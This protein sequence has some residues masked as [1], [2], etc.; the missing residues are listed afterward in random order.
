MGGKVDFG[1]GGTG[2]WDGMH[3]IRKPFFYQAGNQLGHFG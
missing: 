1:D 3:L 2:I